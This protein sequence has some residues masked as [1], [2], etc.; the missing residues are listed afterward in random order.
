MDEATAAILKLVPLDKAY[1]AHDT[2]GL[3]RIQ[4]FTK[5]YF[6]GLLVC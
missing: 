5:G 6:G 4:S 3:Q 1:G 2:T